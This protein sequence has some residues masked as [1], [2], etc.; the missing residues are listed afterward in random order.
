MI[1]KDTNERISIT[2]SKDVLIKLDKM[3]DDEC[4]SRSNMVQYLI[5]KYFKD[6]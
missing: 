2:L 6:K 3:C 5:T 4:R 1:N